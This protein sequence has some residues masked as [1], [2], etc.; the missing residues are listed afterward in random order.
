MIKPS[1]DLF[2]GHAHF[3]SWK[4]W[5]K[6]WKYYVYGAMANGGSIP[7]FFWGQESTRIIN[8]VIKP[9]HDLFSYFGATPVSDCGN[10]GWKIWKYYVFGAMAN[11]GSIP[12]FFGARNRLESSIMLLKFLLYVSVN[13]YYMLIMFLL[14]SK[15]KYIIL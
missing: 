12:M 13:F 8:F 15:T 2:W 1:H 10:I 4:Y 3:R 11:E 5:L 14:Y 9:S 7:M 6:M